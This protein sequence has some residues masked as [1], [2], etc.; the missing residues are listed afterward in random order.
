MIEN[1]CATIVANFRRFTYAHLAQ[2]KYILQDLLNIERVVVHDARI[3]CMKPEL[4]INLL[5]DGCG[6]ESK[7]KETMYVGMRKEFLARLA[8]FAKAHPLVREQIPFLIMNELEI[9]NTSSNLLLRTL[10]SMLCS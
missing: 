6:K 10:L 7:E 9:I 3:L 2:L 5:F 8:N 4:H 1:S